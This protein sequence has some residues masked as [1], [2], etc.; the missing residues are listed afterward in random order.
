MTYYLA[1]VRFK[2]ATKAVYRV[3]DAESPEQARLAIL[4]ATK[5]ATRAV[6]VSVPCNP[7]AIEP[8]AA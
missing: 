7:W 8:K 3:S 2:D 5:G 6:L 4:D 1:A